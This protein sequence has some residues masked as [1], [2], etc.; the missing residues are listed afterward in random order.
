MGCTCSLVGGIKSI[1]G[2]CVGGIKSVDGNCVEPLD[3]AARGV[4]N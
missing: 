4:I 3:S 2:D 1:D